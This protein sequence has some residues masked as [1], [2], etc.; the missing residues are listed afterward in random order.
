MAGCFQRTALLRSG[1]RRV[2]LT[3]AWVASIANGEHAT[4]G[5][6]VLYSYVQYAFGALGNQLLAFL[7]TLACLVTAVDLTCS[8]A[9]SFSKFL[10]FSYKGLVVLLAGFSFL[11]S[12]LG[13]TQQVQIS[14]PVLN[15]I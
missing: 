9:E 1:V 12:N 13:L 15:A 6:E 2:E 7:I 11:S 5:A 4:N 14:V 10:P 3:T 8:C